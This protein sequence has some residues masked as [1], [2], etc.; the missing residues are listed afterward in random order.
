VDLQLLDTPLEGAQRRFLLFPPRVDSPRPGFAAF[1]WSQDGLQVGRYVLGI[2]EP[3]FSLNL[4]VPPGGREDLDVVVPAPVELTVWVVDAATGEEV[5]TDQLQWFQHL[6]IEEMDAGRMVFANA[7]PRR[8]PSGHGYV[9]VAPAVE[10]DLALTHWGYQSW[11]ETLDLGR[12]V[13]EH[14][15]RLQPGCG[16]VLKLVDGRTPLAFPGDWY[17]EVRATSGAGRSLLTELDTFERRFMVS[18]PGTYTVLPPT[19]AGYQPPTLQTVEVL[20][21]EFT[22]VTVELVRLP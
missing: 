13:R 12:G 1:R 17:G 2:Q 9:I 6:S 8:G 7:P 18:H 14:T 15:I 11:H 20:P 3:P 16:L 4:E 5:V 10:I 21:G 19:L 22:E